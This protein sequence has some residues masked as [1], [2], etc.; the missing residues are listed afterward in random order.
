MKFI[1][2][3]YIDRCMPWTKVF[4]VNI[5]YNKGFSWVP[6]EDIVKML[7]HCD[8]HGFIRTHNTIPTEFV[9]ILDMMFEV[10]GVNIKNDFI[11]RNHIYYNGYQ[12][13]CADDRNPY[14]LLPMHMPTA[15][16]NLTIIDNKY[17]YF[18]CT[19]T[20]FYE[21]IDEFVRKELGAGCGNLAGWIVKI[22]EY[23]EIDN[24]LKEIL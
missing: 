11:Y 17:V 24:L 19:T 9:N 18:N 7:V 8:L 21:P 6:A 23:K 12:V 2:W 5:S 22:S 10:Y 14:E 13:K 1:G 20:E 16:A 4:D 3:T 15:N